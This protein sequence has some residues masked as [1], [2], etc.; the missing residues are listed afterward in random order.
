MTQG[1]I[2][3]AIDQLN[4]TQQIKSA[5]TLACSLKLNDPKREVCLVTD[6]FSKV[7]S[8]YESVFDYIIELPFGNTDATESNRAI[9]LWQLYYCTPFAQSMYINPATIAIDNFADFWDICN[10]QDIVFPIHTVNFK[11]Q[12][13][14]YLAKFKTAD[15][16]NILNLNS[17]VFYFEKSEISSEFFK[18]ADV[19][20]Q[21][22]RQWFF[23]YIKEERTNA[24]NSD[25]C[26]GI[27]A[28]AIDYNPFMFE[29]L[30][31]YTD[32]TDDNI[33]EAATQEQSEDWLDTI[34]IWFHNGGDVKV[35]NHRQTGIFVYRQ[36]DLLND[37]A[38]NDISKHYNTTT[39]TIKD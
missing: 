32:L 20:F 21:N 18:M 24:F 2:T 39:T 3:L 15:A 4:S 10:G 29:D 26:F 36:F 27:T 25:L 35:N 11:Q 16:N 33:A 30:L 22:W 5:Y 28:K 13:S 23:E 38:L 34:N 14:Q 7:P 31:E 17:D 1:Y 8:K 37:K 12:P 6:H 19:V 9:N